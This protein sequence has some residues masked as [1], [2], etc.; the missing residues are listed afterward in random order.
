MRAWSAISNMYAVV[1][2]FFWILIAETQFNIY[3]QEYDTQVLKTAV[4]Y[5]S[6][7]A[8]DIALVSSENISNDYIT[9]ESVE[10]EPQKVLE[11]FTDIMCTAYDMYASKTNI[12]LVEDAID[13]L[14]LCGMDG[15]YIAEPTDDGLIFS[16]KMPYAINLKN[17]S[18]I[19]V[20]AT[21]SLNLTNETGLII[22][23][24]KTAPISGQF[25]SFENLNDV[26]IN[27]DIF[28]LDIPEL[29]RLKP[30]LIAGVINDALTKSAEEITAYRQD[31]TF[32]VYIPGYGTEGGIN[33][34]DGPSLIAIMRGTDFTGK[35]DNDE[36]KMSG[37]RVIKPIYVVGFVENGIKYY[38]YETQVPAAY[39]GASTNYYYKSVFEAAANGYSPHMG[40]LG[41]GR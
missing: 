27:L 34:V 39:Q 6:K 17:V 28:G 5:A 41:I 26:A 16:I 37:Y 1:L 22:N 21:I 40:Y 15:Y 9:I 7:G 29:T 12:R 24:A 11:T 2:I 8:M 32:R 35:A 33:S 19:N 38:C 18:S 25:I 14:I 23:N 13:G 30:V 36:V 4:G 31:R 20:D 3:Q 10:I